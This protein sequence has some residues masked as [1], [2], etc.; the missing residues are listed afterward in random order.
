MNA[1]QEQRQKE[2]ITKNNNISRP[3]N[4]SRGWDL[5]SAYSENDKNPPTHANNCATISFFVLHRKV[6]GFN[7]SRLYKTLKRCF[8][9]FITYRRKL[10]FSRVVKRPSN[11]NHL[12]KMQQILRNVR[13]NFI[14][15]VVLAKHRWKPNEECWSIHE[16]SRLKASKSHKPNQREIYST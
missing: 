13:L 15:L 6:L 9:F 12:S 10:V 4:S 1:K 7:K 8:S 11:N 5:G 16:R 3:L 2:N 14:V